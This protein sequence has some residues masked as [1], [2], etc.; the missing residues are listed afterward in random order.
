MEEV[1]IRKIELKISE[2]EWFSTWMLEEVKKSK[3]MM[4]LQ[5][6]ALRNVVKVGAAEFVKS[7]GVKF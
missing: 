6:Q 7:L 1:N 3:G 5:C 2:E 4:I